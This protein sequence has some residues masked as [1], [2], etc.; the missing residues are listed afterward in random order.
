MTLLV[1][2]AILLAGDFGSTF[3]YHVPQHA[4]F[5]L[6]LRT[7]HDRRRS[8]REH[9]ILCA[10]PLILLDGFL[11][12]VPYL[13]V[14]AG[15]WHVSAAGAVLGLAAGQLHVWWRHTAQL[16][17]RT[18]KVLRRLCAVLSIV[19]PE[20]HD[21]HHRNPRVEFGDIFRFYDAPARAFL[22]GLASKKAV[23][24]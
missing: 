16:G 22:A 9:A 2:L 1:A 13:A 14:A 3:L 20:D 19:T 18:P 6:H 5:R 7:H 17:W 15:L 4:W 24:A 12:A 10:D 11:G 23:K 21:C 8:Y